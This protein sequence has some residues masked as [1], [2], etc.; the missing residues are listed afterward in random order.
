MIK[1]KFHIVR[2]KETL[3]DILYI[4]NLNKDELVEQNKHI[5]VWEKLIP[6]TKLR[7]PPI[8]DA[9]EV[10]MSDM[11]PFVEDYYPSI[12]ED[13]GKVSKIYEEEID[14]SVANKVDLDEDKIVVN[15]LEQKDTKESP[16]E[17]AVVKPLE[18]KPLKIENS[19]ENNIPNQ[20][21]NM[22]VKP[23]LNNYYPYYLGM[24]NAPR[25]I[26][27]PIIYYPIYYPKKPN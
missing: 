27:Y 2:N 25:Y 16:K 11:E 4:Y 13:I 15:T 3:E 6:G 5:R 18:D 10:E 12:N 1:L 20:F 23:L 22:Q 8:P 19:I 7:I 14:Q 9:V 17:T 21:S 24:Y 26:P